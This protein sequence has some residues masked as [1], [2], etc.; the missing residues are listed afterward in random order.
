VLEAVAFVDAEYLGD[1]R[2]RRGPQ[3]TTR[4]SRLRSSIAGGVRYSV[5]PTS[6][7]MPRAV[8]VM[9]SIAAVVSRG[10]RPGTRGG[11]VLCDLNVHPAL[12]WRAILRRARIAIEVYTE[13]TDE[14]TRDALRKLG[15]SA[16]ETY[17]R[18]LLLYFAAVPAAEKISVNVS[19]L[20]R[21]PSKGLEP[22]TFRLQGPRCDVRRGSSV[23]VCPAC[24]ISVL[25]ADAGG[26]G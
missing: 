25:V 22:L 16:G 14:A 19:D 5:P 12:L 11:P 2:E 13:V 17:R 4:P 10:S 23:Y 24:G 21:E 15:D 3:T 1:D 6:T 7:L 18:M 9:V 20:V 26:H 8:R